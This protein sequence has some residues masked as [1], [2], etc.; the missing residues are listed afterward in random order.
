MSGTT[1]TGAEHPIRVSHVIT[2]LVAGGTE[3]MLQR[4]VAETGGSGIQHQVISLTAG[5]EVADEL[6]AMGVPVASLDMRRTGTVP[7]LHAIWRLATYLRDGAPHV[8]QAWMYH[9]N[10]LA[11]VASLLAGTGRAVWGVRAASLPTGHERTR[12]IVLARVSAALAGSLARGVVVNGDRARQTHL[13]AGY[14]SA[15]MVTIPNGYDLAVWHFDE[16]ARVHVR[17]ELGIGPDALIIGMIANFRPIKDHRTFFRAI[18]ELRRTHSNIHV[19]LAGVDTGAGV[20]EFRRLVEQELG[21]AA[22]VS[23]L[24]S[25]GDV[26]RLTAALDVAVLSSIDESFPNVVAEA[27]ACEVPVVT[28]DAGDVRTILGGDDD[29]VSV[30]D[31]RAL[32]ERLRWWL[33][34]SR[35]SRRE[36]GAVLRARI[37][38]RYSL[39]A[40]AQQ[41]ARYWRALAGDSSSDR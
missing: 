12:T 22:G 32:A 41:Y 2:T 33:D 7:D 18:A 38:R 16:S 8:V 3:R 21:S 17:R 1:K 30:G 28:T 10:V 25:R 23:A 26:P 13:A 35:E 19:L 9:A 29:V 24:G 31:H 4:I 36:H 5:G 15:K 20:P 37:A 11:S 14:P 39:A 40:V 34:Q 6:R 27:M